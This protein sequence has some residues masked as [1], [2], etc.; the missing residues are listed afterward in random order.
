MPRAGAV[1]DPKIL[2]LLAQ[3]RLSIKKA[4]AARGKGKAWSGIIDPAVK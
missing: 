3:R 4:R 2:A 1:E